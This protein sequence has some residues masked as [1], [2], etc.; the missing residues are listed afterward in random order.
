MVFG[1]SRNMWLQELCFI[2][3]LLKLFD[4]VLTPMTFMTWL[5]A[6]ISY[7]YIVLGAVVVINISMELG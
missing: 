1:C 7:G 4:R 3:R 6:Q 5:H 2:G